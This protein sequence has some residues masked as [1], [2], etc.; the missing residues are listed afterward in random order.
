[1]TNARLKH[2][3]FAQGMMQSSPRRS[4][5]LA[6]RPISE[7]GKAKIQNSP[8]EKDVPKKAQGE[9]TGG[10]VSLAYASDTDED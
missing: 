7:G 2:D 3:P 4:R 1:M 5:R 10:V 9:S 8:G 6:S